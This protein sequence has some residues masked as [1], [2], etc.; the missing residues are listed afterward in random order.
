[1]QLARFNPSYGLHALRAQCKNSVVVFISVSIPHMGCMPYGPGNGQGGGAP[2]PVSIPHM[3]C[4]PYGPAA[5]IVAVLRNR[6]F[7]PSYGLHALRAQVRGCSTET[8]ETFQSLIWVACPTGAQLPHAADVFRLFQSLIW[9]ACPTGFVLLLP[10]LQG[11]M[12]QSLIWV[13]CPTGQHRP[14]LRRVRSAVSIP[15]M[16]CMPYGLTDYD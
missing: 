2:R 4:M 9:V 8:T 7:N 16:G 11:K 1:M 13:A 12:F 14:A 6:C 10:V 3:G 5:G 15:H